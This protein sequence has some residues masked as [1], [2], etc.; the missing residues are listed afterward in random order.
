[1]I[2]GRRGGEVHTHGF[3]QAHNRVI[4]LSSSEIRSRAGQGLGL[5]YLLPE[6][7]FAYIR[8]KGLYGYR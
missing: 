7:V 8:E 5:R 6:A 1:I 2:V 3:A 4:P